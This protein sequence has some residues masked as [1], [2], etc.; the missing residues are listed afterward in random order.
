M[1]Q[2]KELFFN[3]KIDAEGEGGKSCNYLLAKNMHCFWWIIA[4]SAKT[5]DDYQRNLKSN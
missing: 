2:Y 3:V 5:S 1:A 4:A